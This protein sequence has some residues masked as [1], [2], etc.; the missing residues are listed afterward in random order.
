MICLS[1]H[2]V[3]PSQISD[4]IANGRREKEIRASPKIE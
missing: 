2:V 1:F 3:P 4:R